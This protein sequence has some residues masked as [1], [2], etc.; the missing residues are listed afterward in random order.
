ML[1]GWRFLHPC[2][3]ISPLTVESYSLPFSVSGA[4]NELIVPC[5][6]EQVAWEGIQAPLGHID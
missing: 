5:K 6:A 2:V 4:T 3:D 1:I